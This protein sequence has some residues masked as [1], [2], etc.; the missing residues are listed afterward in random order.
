MATSAKGQT[1][2]QLSRGIFKL[3][4][5][6]G[7]NGFENRTNRRFS[8]ATSASIIKEHVQRCPYFRS[9]ELPLSFRSR[10]LPEKA[11]RIVDKTIH[12][13]RAS[14][15]GARGPATDARTSISTRGGHRPVGNEF[16]IDFTGCTGAG[17]GVLTPAKDRSVVGILIAFDPDF[18]KRCG[19]RAKLRRKASCDDIIDNAFCRDAHPADTPRQA[20][21]SQTLSKPLRLAFERRKFASSGCSASCLPGRIHQNPGSAGQSQIFACPRRGCPVSRRS[22]TLRTHGGERPHTWN[23]SLGIAIRN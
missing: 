15:L 2:N 6:G 3:D 16:V 14:K 17:P 20:E 13:C 11:W 23:P 22:G 21:Y 18:R 8:Q 9:S 12:D 1:V 19:N 5:C 10:F 7:L 4:L